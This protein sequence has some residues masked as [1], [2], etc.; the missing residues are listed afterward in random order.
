MYGCLGNQEKQTRE[1]TTTKKQGNKK[2]KKPKKQQ[3]NLP[4][5]RLLKGV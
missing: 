2:L 4:N 1:K 5:T 3:G